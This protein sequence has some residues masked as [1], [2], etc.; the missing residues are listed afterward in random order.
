ML[1]NAYQTTLL[2]IWRVPNITSVKPFQ[3]IA[4]PNVYPNPI[5]QSVTI[6]E[7]PTLSS[8]YL[9]YVFNQQGQLIRTI[10]LEDTSSKITID[11]PDIQSGIYFLKL[12]GDQYHYQFKVIK[13]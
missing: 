5:T 13:I 1:L 4:R 6:D 10:E 9:V 3:E 2:I 12:V 11:L 8:D 7:L